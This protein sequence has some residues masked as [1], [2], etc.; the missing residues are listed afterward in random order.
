LDL[1]TFH[2]DLSVGPGGRR[3]DGLQQVSTF[4]FESSLRLFST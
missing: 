1:R 3:L 4:W 2:E